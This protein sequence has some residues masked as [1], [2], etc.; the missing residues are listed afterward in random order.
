MSL[1]IS[2]ISSCFL[3]RAAAY[4]SGSVLPLPFRP[5][6]LDIVHRRRA[7][8]A[9]KALAR[10]AVAQAAVGHRG[11]RVEPVRSRRGLTQR[12]R[13]GVRGGRR[14]RR[15]VAAQQVTRGR[16]GHEAG[17]AGGAAGHTGALVFWQGE[18]FAQRQGFGALPAGAAGENRSSTCLGI[19][20]QRRFTV[21]P[22][23][24]EG[25]P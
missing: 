14:R 17:G 8:H 4:G 10:A 19:L 16:W 11:V 20:P 23:V 22:G 7:P 2:C 6:G 21:V 3:T 1:L 12:Q 9:V 5:H 25:K 24:Q 18:E 15:G 13:D